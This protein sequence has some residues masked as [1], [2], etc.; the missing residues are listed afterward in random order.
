VRFGE[1]MKKQEIIDWECLGFIIDRNICE[2][3]KFKEDMKKED[4]SYLIERADKK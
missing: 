2:K 4:C 3:C 1:Q